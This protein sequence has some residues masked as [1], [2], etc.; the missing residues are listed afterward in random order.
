M[1]DIDI[2]NDDGQFKFR[3]CGIIVNKDKVLIQKMAK[4]EGY[5]FPGGHV[6]LGETSYDAVIRE[7]KEELHIDT[8]VTKLL[9]VNEN[10]YTNTSNKIGHEIAYYYLL[11]PLQELPE[12]EFDS[13]ET[14]IGSVQHFKWVNIKE[15][16]KEILHP[17]FLEQILNSGK[18]YPEIIIT[19][20][21]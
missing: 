4:L 19:D 13:K 6:E 10:I 5:C 14:S 18:E 2:R 20:Q 15:L 11:K 8:E 3:S 9:C 21:R 7:I 12:K 17:Y 16:H 1:I